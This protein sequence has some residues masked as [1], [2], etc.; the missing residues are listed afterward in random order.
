MCKS[1][2]VKKKP[3]RL[4]DCEMC[5]SVPWHV[6][7]GF[8]SQN[9][10]KISENVL[11]TYKS[12]CRVESFGYDSPRTTLRTISF[13]PK[14]SIRI[15][16]IHEQKD[17]PSFDW[18]SGVGS[19]GRNLNIYLKMEK[20]TILYPKPWT[21]KMVRGPVDGPLVGVLWVGVEFHC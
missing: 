3:W 9:L 4:N 15:V 13:D 12:V 2:N 21:N 19:V 16:C 7:W 14:L 17:Y 18:R 10:V 6:S 20:I 11:N 8:T 5:A 1:Q